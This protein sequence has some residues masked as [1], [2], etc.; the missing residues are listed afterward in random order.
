MILPIVVAL[1]GSHFVLT[2][3]DKI[4][5]F[6]IDATCRVAAVADAEVLGQGGTQGCK[7]DEQNALAQLE[8]QWNQFPSSDRRQC[9][10]LASETDEPSYV[11]LL[12]CLE[13]Q[14]DAG[15][16]HPD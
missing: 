6:D 8:K 15:N 12:T 10:Q 3:L 14:R 4:P 9:Q 16:S 2:A 13:M 11:E 7:D 1:F 5:H